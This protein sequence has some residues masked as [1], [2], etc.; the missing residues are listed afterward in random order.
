MP[1]VS[2]LGSKLS[3]VAMLTA[4]CLLVQIAPSVMSIT[5]EAAEPQQSEPT[6][7]ERT[8]TTRGGAMTLPEGGSTTHAT[9][10]PDAPTTFP[11][12][13][14]P[15]RPTIDKPMPRPAGSSLPIDQNNPLAVALDKA[16]RTQNKVELTADRT[17]TNT[18]WANPDGTL[19]TETASGPVRVKK[20]DEFVAVD[21]TLLTES[22][23]VVTRATAGN[24]VLSAGGPA[25]SPLV[26]LGPKGSRLTLGWNQA[27]P[28]PRLEGDTAT[29]SDVA[30]GQ[31]VVVKASTIGFES[32]VVLKERPATA[33][34]IT[35]PVQ[36]D[37]L[38]LSEDAA[39]QLRLANAKGEV[40]V[41]SSAPLMYSSAKDPK[42]GEH[43]QNKMIE[44]AVT[45]S[46]SGAA[47]L[48]LEPD[49]A[50]LSDPSTEYPV[51]IDP[52]GSLTDTLD[53]YVDSSL[54]DANYDSA[55]SLKVGT[56]NGGATKYRSFIRF[57][58]A[59]LKGLSV[60]SATLHLYQTGAASCTVPANLQVD[61]AGAFG[62]G[63]T[64]NNQ[65]AMENIPWYLG[66]HGGNSG[67]T[68]YP[69]AWKSMNVTNLAQ[70][71]AINGHSSPDY[72]ALR[73][74]DETVTAQNKTFAA[75]GTTTPPTINVTYSAAPLPTA[76]RDVTVVAG[77][78]QATLYW[79]IPIFPGNPPADYFEAYIYTYPGIVPVGPPVKVC[80]S[81]MSATVPSVNGQQYIA[82]VYAHNSVGYGPFGQSPVW[83][84]GG[85]PNAAA[86]VVATAR[87]GSAT[88]TGT[89]TI[90]WSPSTAN[91]P[92]IDGYLISAS[93]APGVTNNFMTVG[94]GV[95]FL[96]YTQPL[97]DGHGYTFAVWP[98][99][100]AGYGAY[101][102]SNVTVPGPT[103]AMLGAGDRSRFSHD[104]VSLN[105]R[106]TASVN[107]GTG[108]LQVSATDLIL[109]GVSGSM[110]VGRVYNSLSSS[111]SA[112]G[113]SSWYSSMFGYGWRSNQAPDTRLVPNATGSKVAFNGPSGN[114]TVF[115]K[116]LGNPETD[117]QADGMDVNLK[118]VTGGYE[119]TDHVSQQLLKFTDSGD[120][121]EDIDR[122]GNKVEFNFT[123]GRRHPGPIVANAG[124]VSGTPGGTEVIYNY[125]GPTGK[126]SAVTQ[127]AGTDAAARAVNFTYDSA[128]I[129]LT[130]VVDAEGGTT[131]YGY[132]RVANLVEIN[133]AAGHIT[134]FTYDAKHRVT[135]MI[136]K[137]TGKPDVVTKYG[138]SAATLPYHTTVTDP[139]GNSPV[140]Y[141]IDASARVTKV[142]DAFGRENSTVWNS[143]DKVTSSTNG[144]GGTT[145]NVWGA[146]GGESLTKSTGPTGVISDSL[147]GNTD[148][149]TAWLPSEAAKSAQMSQDDSWTDF[150][151]STGGRRDKVTN[152]F[153]G[154][155]SLLTINAADGTVTDSVTPE[156]LTA[157]PQDVTKTTR[158]GYTHKLL[159]SVDH[160]DEGG[161]GTDTMTYDGAGRLRTSTSGEGMRT[162][163]TYDQMDRV[164]NIVFTDTVAP[165]ETI[166]SISFVFDNAGNM[167]SRSDPATTIYV[168]DDLNRMTK[169]DLPVGDDLTYTYDPAGNLT[170]SSTGSP[171][172]A[173]NTTTYRYNKS[174]EMDKMTEPVKLLSARTN[175]FGYNELGQ[176]SDTWYNTSGGGTY[177]GNVFNPP[178]GFAA[179]ISQSYDT[180][181]H[182]TNIKTTRASSDADANRLS[183][184]TYS[185]TV[186]SPSACPGAAVGMDTDNRQTVKDNLTGRTTTYCYAAM[187][188][189]I[190]ASTDNGGPVYEYGWD[191]NSNRETDEAGSHVF[192]DADQLVSGT[193]IVYDQNGNQTASPTFPA[194]AYNGINQTESI[195]PAGQAAVAM[196]YA[197]SGQAERTSAGGTTARNGLLG[198]ETETTGG[199]ETVYRRDA[200]GGLVLIDGP[201]IDDYYFYFDGL[202][203]VIGLVDPSGN[204]RATYSYD[205]FGS[206]A[207]ATAANGLLP[208]NPWRWMGGYLDSTGLYHF[209]ERYYDPALARFLQPDPIAGGSCNAYD[210]VCGDPVNL[211]DLT[212]TAVYGTCGVASYGAP[213]VVGGAICGLNDDRGNV[214]LVFIASAGV[215]FEMGVG[216]AAFYSN[217]PT[218]NDVLGN[219]AC[220]GAGLGAFAEGCSWRSKKDGKLYFATL[221]GSSAGS[222]GVRVGGH[223]GISHTG[224]IR[225]IPNFGIRR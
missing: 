114:V 197:G 160:P 104:S 221:G 192:N 208:T 26:A 87:S 35:I 92:A 5:A 157:S 11:D 216:G 201:S 154:T 166:P 217:A 145:T 162:T 22:G 49:F 156:N 100:S 220:I 190:M 91:G 169:K 86:N 97:L 60:T 115:S 133:D 67:C 141:E 116:V 55:T 137:I 76:P 18:T 146:N 8:G 129:G 188:Q 30:P 191:D 88:A 218:I 34:V 125:S 151:Y 180:A 213:L 77:N 195:T 51:F 138:Y 152:R 37:G 19:S 27:L 75:A 14:P 222:P 186:P 89:A 4:L 52:T 103:D 119:M 98:H 43:S 163:R 39:G 85:Q 124:A 127:P 101:A 117:Y 155:S 204:Q 200:G 23:K 12:A 206:H 74:P 79:T 6:P 15:L 102:I 109:P 64:W 205:P 168:Y 176:R 173:A 181:G 72:L 45:K 82:N 130:K 121:F 126:V 111:H 20:G 2:R 41:S 53:T 172:T 219:S 112:P 54:P 179:H 224:K 185:Y 73:A 107:L 183:D 84:P 94:P 194:V 118:K 147:Y 24:L 209:G 93:N 96:N 7:D 65:P 225:R 165:I 131:L 25:G 83:T 21:P 212:G 187:G 1:R 59:W 175:L 171:V 56:P 142:T 122:F 128:G 17:E 159:T 174:N 150:T 211:R 3:L 140:D 50:F 71:W 198:V 120:L 95:S 40:V 9:L 62:P 143:D 202:G 13:P 177:T 161:L 223:F 196:D 158:Y 170:S 189:L 182:L 149:K 66:T 178:T 215:G 108:N 36:T 113:V 58:D 78:N 48:V 70:Q 99:S 81:C 139:N 210:Y 31:D 42:S 199:Q 207:T 153:T 38:T 47:Q 57:D 203:S 29:Y 123:D 61:A 63:T 32:F 16:H 80:G 164:T 144:D 106:T 90:R 134:N 46:S 148:P 167:I 110:P 193:A 10:P 33:P 28:A 69:A 44:T 105:D 135:S 184:L 68:G 136:R 132:D 214:M